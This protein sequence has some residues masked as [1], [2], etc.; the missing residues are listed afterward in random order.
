MIRRFL[1][2]AF[3]FVVAGMLGACAHS[4]SSTASGPR[5]GVELPLLTSPFWQAYDQ[6]LPRYAQ[7]Y[8][9]ALLPPS[10]ANGDENKFLTDVQSMIGEGVQG[11]VLSPTDTAAVVTAIDRAQRAKIPAV[12]VDVAPDRGSVYMVVRADNVAYGRK[13]CE[14][15]GAHVHTGSVVQVE[16]DLASINGRERTSAFDGCMRSKF[17]SLHVLR[18]AAQWDG[19]KAAQG[20]DAVFAAHPDIKGIYLQAGGVYL[21]PTLSFLRRHDALVPAGS[22]QHV[23]IV[24]NDGIPQ[25]LDAIRKGWIDATVSQPADA[26]ARY[27]MY[28]IH[29][30]L[31]G[32]H[33]KPGP[34]DH[35]STIVRLPNGM[36]ED[37]L[38]APLVTKTN[39]DD[40]SLWGNTVK[41]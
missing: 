29:A 17:P 41:A 21:S 13:A 39:V 26:Y 1:R 12:T 32:K 7:Q 2:A 16:G 24:S 9:I 4:G 8:G 14:Y 28:Y 40:A 15:L 23:T 37:E 30:A 25:E 5:V 11:L 22:P 10:D 18:V 38:P 36:L 31:T 19:A 20:L 3:P 34:T 33:F 27:G 6:Y 35:G